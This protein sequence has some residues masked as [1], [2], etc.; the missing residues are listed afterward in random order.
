MAADTGS[1]VPGA[2]LNKKAKKGGVGGTAKANGHA[3]AALPAAATKSSSADPSSMSEKAENKAAVAAVDIIETKDTAGNPLNSSP[4]AR[5]LAKR[6]KA[7]TKKLQRI[8]QYEESAPQQ[9]NEDQKK[10]IASKGSLHAV[11][12]ELTEV[13]KGL[14]VA[15]KELL[16]EGQAQ[17]QVHGER[18]K[19]G[20]EVSGGRLHSR[21]N[22]LSSD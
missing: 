18:E 8:S 19:R 17:E 13:G 14:E 10:A 21:A 3:S 5:V 22:T 1:A 11:L 12:K 20:A 7:V 15:E 2:A 16:A 6:V 9:L 4:I